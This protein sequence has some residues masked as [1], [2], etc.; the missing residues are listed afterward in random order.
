MSTA[1]SEIA[2]RSRKNFT[3]I[4]QRLSSLGQGSLAAGLG[5]SEASISR[6]KTEQAEQCAKAL[7]LLGLKVVPI[8]MRCFDPQRIGAIL[9][10]AKA[11]LAEIEK[12]EQLAW[13]E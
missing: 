1:S 3:L 10:L 11:H 4:L 12:P 6:W 9:E 13:E 8:E 7:A 2:E 5:V